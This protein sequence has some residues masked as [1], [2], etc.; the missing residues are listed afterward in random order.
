MLPWPEEAL[1]AQ[2]RDLPVRL[3]AKIVELSA[4]GCKYQSGEGAWEVQGRIARVLA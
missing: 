3:Q 2:Q 4:H 1:C